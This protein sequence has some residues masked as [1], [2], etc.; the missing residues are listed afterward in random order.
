VEL[1]PKKPGGL[2]GREGNKASPGLRRGGVPRKLAGE[3]L[4]CSLR[5]GQFSFRLLDLSKQEARG[6]AFFACQFGGAPRMRFRIGHTPSLGVCGGEEEMS[7]PSSAILEEGLF[8]CAD[9]RGR[10]SIAELQFAQGEQGSLVR[11]VNR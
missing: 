11:R 1:T 8:Q 5:C 4:P 7:A 10:F 3:I 6:C 2:R 9:S